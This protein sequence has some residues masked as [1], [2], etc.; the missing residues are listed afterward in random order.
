MQQIFLIGNLTADAEVKSATRNGNKSEFVSFK[1]ACNEQIGDE[2]TTTYYDVTMARTGVF[3]FLKKGQ[4]VGVVGRFKFTVSRDGNG[5][6]YPHLNVSASGVELAGTP[7]SRE[8]VP[9]EN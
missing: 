9:A 1:L 4:K 5:K 3:D 2:K 6:E 8:D 7:R